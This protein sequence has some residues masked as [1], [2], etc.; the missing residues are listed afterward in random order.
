MKPVSISRWDIGSMRT[1]LEAFERLL[2]IRVPWQWGRG[3]AGTV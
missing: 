1:C 3:G 2:R